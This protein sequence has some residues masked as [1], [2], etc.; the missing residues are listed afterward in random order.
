MIKIDNMEDIEPF[1]VK[2]YLLSRYPNIHGYV[3]ISQ[4]NEDFKLLRQIKTNLSRERINYKLLVNCVVMAV[5]V[6]DKD[7]I[8]IVPFYFKGYQVVM[9]NTILVYLNRID[10]SVPTDSQFM[11][12]L[13][14]NIEKFRG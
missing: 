9:L 8:H 7:F 6:F 13:K 11:N 4:F 12:D 14:N 5:N 10:F 2:D 1:N 3:N